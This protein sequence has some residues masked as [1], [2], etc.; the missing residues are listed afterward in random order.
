MMVLNRRLVRI[1][2]DDKGQ[3]VHVYELKEEDEPVPDEY[4]ISVRHFEE[5]R[6]TLH[7]D[8]PFCQLNKKAK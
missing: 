3:E 5:H 2:H 1:E 7:A 8:C 4:Y 6:S